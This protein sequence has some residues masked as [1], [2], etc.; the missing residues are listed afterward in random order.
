[1]K[2][3]GP[4]GV[5]AIVVEA[6]DEVVESGDDTSSKIAKGILE[7]VVPLIAEACNLREMAESSIPE[8][9][10]RKIVEKYMGDNI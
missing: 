3:V 8:N 5:L 7:T 4:C 9:K 10:L 6:L 1:M 2:R